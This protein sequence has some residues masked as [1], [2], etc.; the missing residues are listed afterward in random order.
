MPTNEYRGSISIVFIMYYSYVFEIN[1]CFSRKYRFHVD[2]FPVID[3]YV[4]L[5]NNC[6][7]LYDFSVQHLIN[8]QTTRN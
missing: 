3:L 8:T 5:I 6:K 4:L 2:C 1:A 7:I